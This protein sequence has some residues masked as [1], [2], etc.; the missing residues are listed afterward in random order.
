MSGARCPSALIWGAGGSHYTRIYTHIH[1]YTR[2]YAH[3]RIYTHIHAC[4]RIYTHI[5]AYTRIYTHTHIYTH[6]Q[7]YTHIHAYARIHAYT[8]MYNTC[9]YT[10][11]LVFIT[12]Q[13]QVLN[14]RRAYMYAYLHRLVSHVCTYVNGDTALVAHLLYVG[15][16]GPAH[17]W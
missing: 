10:L 11:I 8:R 15:G 9:I 4:A 6:I 5:H 7:A 2:I 14:S 13:F 17:L 3:V 1:A 16:Y 12:S